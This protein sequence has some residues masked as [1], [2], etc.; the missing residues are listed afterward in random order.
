MDSSF[1]AALDCKLGAVIDSKPDIAL[2][3]ELV[4]ALDSKLC[5]TLV[6]QLVAALDFKLSEVLYYKLRIIGPSLIDQTYQLVNPTLSI[7]LNAIV[8]PGHFHP[9]CILF[10]FRLAELRRLWF[11]Q[12]IFPL[13]D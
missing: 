5:A 9:S 4:A 13:A 10:I 7:K 1:A 12:Y 8:K 6:F 11:G 3:S 2:G